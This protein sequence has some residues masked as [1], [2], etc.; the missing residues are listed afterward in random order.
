MTVAIRPVAARCGGCNSDSTDND[1]GAQN[2]CR[3]SLNDNE[4]GFLSLL[5]EGTEVD[6]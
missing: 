5:K 1:V 6:L 2:W 4:K 3:G